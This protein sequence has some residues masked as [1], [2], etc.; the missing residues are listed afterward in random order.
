MIRLR[1]VVEGQT[2]EEFVNSVLCPHLGDFNVSADARAVETSRRKRTGKVFRGG[3]T[4]YARAKRDLLQWMKEDG[5]RDAR[6]T[7]MFDLYGLPKDFPG[8]DEARRKAVPYE[9][10]GVLETAFRDDL[11]DPRFVPYIQLHEFEALL[12][13]DPSKFVAQ[14]PD[15]EA[16]IRRLVELSSDAPSPE[17]IDDGDETAPSK[18]IIQAIPEYERSKTSAG[19]F[20]GEQIG[21]G[22]IRDK[23]RHF[24]E[25]LTTLEELARTGV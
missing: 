11:G 1:I 7:T 21:L 3:M 12:L 15:R 8:Y 19:P 22:T 17:L 24:N 9:R 25:W 14:F 4:N 6:F 23:C 2:E 10:V 16:G 5:R 13:A 20:I 18:R